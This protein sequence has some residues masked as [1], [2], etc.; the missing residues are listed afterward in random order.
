MPTRKSDDAVSLVRRGKK[1]KIA[2]AGTSVNLDELELST[3]ERAALD[4]LI[5]TQDLRQ[6]TPSE[7]K[8]LKAKKSLIGDGAQALIIRFD[9]KIVR[10]DEKLPATLLRGPKV[11]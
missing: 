8:L 6:L 2:G 4:K 10:I 9:V 5:A 11:K 7:Q 1:L 3:D